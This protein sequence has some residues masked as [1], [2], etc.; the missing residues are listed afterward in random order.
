MR[1]GVARADISPEP[2]TLMAGYIGRTAPAEDLH[3]PLFARAILLDDG[4]RRVAILGADLLAVDRAFAARLRARLQSELDIAPSHSLLTMSHTHSGPLMWSR[5]H[6]D[7]DPAYLQ[8]VEDTLVEVARQAASDLRL[9]RVGAGRVKLYLGVN[10]RQ[11]NPD[12]KVILGKNPT[13]YASPYCRIL[14]ALEEGHG[15]LGIFFA[16]GAHPVVLGPENLRISGDYAGRAERQVEENFGGHAVAL[17]ALGFAGDVNAAY[18]KRDFD[19]VETI[20]SA[21]ARAV[22]EEL[23]EIELSPD[24]ALAARS[25]VVALPTEPAPSPAEAERLF[26]GERERLAALF[27]RGEERAQVEHQRRMVEWAS[28]LGELAHQGATDPSVEL[29]VQTIRVGRAG[30]VALSAEVFAGFEKDAL[31]LSPC[32]PTFLV[33]NA[34]G[35]IGYLPTT[36]AMAEGGYEVEIAHRYFGSLRLSPRAPAVAEDAL[37]AALAEMADRPQAPDEAPEQATQP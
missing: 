35:N 1:C 17:F 16:Y 4:A 23:K 31:P 33:S 13:G 5:A 21:L 3:D 15:P 14:L 22:L 12:G 2:G 20:G 36:E 18:E 28:R 30:L 32:Q 6:N 8:R 24:A 25:T 11:R 26:Y 37:R 29:E 19:E 10:R 34:N 27:G 9:A 7:P